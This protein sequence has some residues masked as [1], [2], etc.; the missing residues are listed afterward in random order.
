M[1]YPPPLEQKQALVTYFQQFVTP[2]R[3][4]KIEA[5]LSQRTRHLTVMVNDFRNTQNG[6]AILR[7]CEGLGLQDVHIVEN[8]NPFKVNRDV[9]RNCQKWL[10]LHRYNQPKTNNTATC[11]AALRSQGYRL[12]A[13]SPHDSALPPEALPL[14]NK[15]AILMG[16]E[17][18]GL[19]DAVLRQADWT[20]QIPM[21]GFTESFNVSVS[22]AVCLYV[23]T[24]QLR[25]SQVPWQLSEPERL[26]LK[27]DWYKLSSRSSDYLERRFLRQRGWLP[28]SGSPKS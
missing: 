21:V 3:Q 4:A 13:T 25:V 11:L 26:H 24:R 7:T 14:E 5:S 2:E 27:L 8:Q 6:S 12:V 10:T 19:P 9:T 28:A 20:I 23:L 18:E 15:V 1:A 17:Q 16:S 22:A